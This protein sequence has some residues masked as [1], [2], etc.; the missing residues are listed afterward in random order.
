MA[1]GI[2]YHCGRNVAWDCL[3]VVRGGRVHLDGDMDDEEDDTKE[4]T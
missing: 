4:D 3:E 1:T 2:S